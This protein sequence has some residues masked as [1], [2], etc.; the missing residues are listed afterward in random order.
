MFVN[1]VNDRQWTRGDL[2][3]HVPIDLLL[4][5]PI[6][7]RRE[8]EIVEQ[9]LKPLLGVVHAEIVKGRTISRASQLPV[10]EARHI[11]DMDARLSLDVARR[12]GYQSSIDEHHQSVE[13]L[14]VETH[15]KRIKK[16]RPTSTDVGEIERA[17]HGCGVTGVLSRGG[18]VEEVG[19]TG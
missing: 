10:L 12:R 19:E 1:G 17:T 18:G 4:H 5:V 14:V 8:R 2:R 11:D 3:Q 16:G 15:H 6:L 13:G 7:L 9:H